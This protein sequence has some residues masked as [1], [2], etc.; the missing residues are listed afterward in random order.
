MIV[1]GAADRHA[2]HIGVFGDGTDDGDGEHQELGILMGGVAGIEEV[3][4][5]VGGHRPVIVLARAVDSRERLFVEQAGQTVFVGGLLHHLHGEVLVIG[6]EIR[7]LED[8]GKFVLARSHF[9]VARL[10]WHAELEE[11]GFNV[12]HI[13]QHALGNGAEILVFHFLALGG[14]GAEEGSSGADQIGPKRSKSACR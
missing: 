1:V 12:G 3:F 14:L 10:H 6:P 13:R 9:V 8:R 2:Q 11:R 7:V 5:R 4:A